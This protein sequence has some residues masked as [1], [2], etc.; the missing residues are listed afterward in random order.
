[1]TVAQIE[2]VIGPVGSMMD[3]REARKTREETA[4]MQRET[5]KSE[6]DRRFDERRQKDK[7]RIVE[8]FNKDSG[9]KKIEA[10]MDSI[11]EVRAMLQSGNPIGDAAVQTVMPRLMGEVG[12]L[13]EADKRP[14]G[15]SRAIGPRIEQAMSEAASG[16]MTPKN[17][18]FINGLI[19]TV[20]KRALANKDR[21]ARELSLQFAAVNPSMD[22][23]EIYDAVRPIGSAGRPANVADVGSEEEAAA[24]PVGTKF[25]LPDGRTGTVKED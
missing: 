23:N 16:R 1:M 19:D 7:D 8:N 9:V 24:L 11:S 20:E 18:A 14:F 6:R 17:R 25:R 22:V 12:A 3:R 13:T 21:R 15:G 5:L 4:R 10:R 2:K